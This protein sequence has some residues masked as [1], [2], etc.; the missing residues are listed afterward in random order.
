[1]LSSTEIR[2]LEEKRFELQSRLDA[3]KRQDKRN[4]LGQFSTPFKLAKEI[5]SAALKFLPK[6]SSIRFLEPGFGTGTFFSALLQCA[7]PERIAAAKGVEVDP[8]YGAPAKE[9]WAN[10]GAEVCIGDFTE[11][12][13]PVNSKR[14]NLLVC[15]PPYSRH[16]HL[17]KHQKL[18]LQRA[19][20]GASARLSGLA[21]L[22][23]Y[24]L[25]LA[26]NW[27]AE[28]GIAAWLIPSEFMEVNY[29]SQLRKYLLTRG[30]LLRLHLFDPADVQFGDA[31]VSSA[32]LFFRKAPA[33]LNHHV[34]FTFGSDVLRPTL[35]REIPVS[36][37][38]EQVR[39]PRP[40]FSVAEEPRTGYTLSDFFSIKRGIATGDNSFFILTREQ[41]D[42]HKLPFK[43][44]K[45]ILPSPRHIQGDE[46]IADESGLPN[47]TPRL[48]LLDCPLSEDELR[49]RH[50][51]LS[52]YLSEGKK[53]RVEQRY[54]C[55]HRDPW[56]SQERRAPAPFLCTY[57]GRVRAESGKAFR[58]LLNR[59]RATAPNVYLLLYPTEVLANALHAD[60]SLLL[61]V[62]KELQNATPASV[63]GQARTY[64]GGLHKWE[65]SELGRVPADGIA[66]LLNLA[67]KSSAVQL[68]LFEARIG[69]GS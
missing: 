40:P 28:Q 59:S 38:R 31:L 60:E 36:A 45:P 62:W 2:A 1:M 41:I 26:D 44:F 65:P 7:G 21:G 42:E 10:A 39:W 69:A 17:S 48:F 58:F 14:F 57:M 15:N 52:S 63:L 47:V 25:L 46:I 49:E 23:C 43:F 18:R 61:R 54:L 50:P 56:Y 34:Q 67:P 27:M 53:K 35:S 64:G 19:L 33:P 4:E 9:L 22:H 5:V 68:K 3:G 55:R 13:P 37:L 29:G 32:V 11:S 6:T 24:F 51:R 8:Y 12:E 66:A 16:H 20:N 30:T